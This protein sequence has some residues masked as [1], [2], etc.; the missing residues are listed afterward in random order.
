MKLFLH[1]ISVNCSNSNV[2]NIKP[3]KFLSALSDSFSFCTQKTPE[4][5]TISLSS[6]KYKF[7]PEQENILALVRI[8]YKI[9]LNLISFSFADRRSSV[10][11][12]SSW[13]VFRQDVRDGYKVKLFVYFCPN[14]SKELELLFAVLILF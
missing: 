14:N 5:H 9:S 7:W 6:T 3:L 1:T 2:S 11:A 12:Y 10:R 4:K 8:S 13:P